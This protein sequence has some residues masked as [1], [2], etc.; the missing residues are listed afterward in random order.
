MN[1]VCIMIFVFTSVRRV[2]TGIIQPHAA[3]MKLLQL[4]FISLVSNIFITALPSI[5]ITKK[6]LK[7][8]YLYFDSQLN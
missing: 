8:P 6:I 1:M 3:Q 4:N 5:T 2:T 7:A